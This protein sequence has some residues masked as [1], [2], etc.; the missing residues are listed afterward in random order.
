MAKVSEK[1]RTTK[2]AS[3]RK[4]RLVINEMCYTLHEVSEI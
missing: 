2:K 3:L 1:Y 4:D